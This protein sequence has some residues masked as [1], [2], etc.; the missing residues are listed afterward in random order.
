MS[1][2]QLCRFGILHEAEFI[3]RHLSGII[4]KTISKVAIVE[5]LYHALK[6]KVYSDKEA[7]RIR[8]GAVTT[9]SQRAIYRPTDACP[10]GIRTTV[11]AM[12]HFD[13]IERLWNVAGVEKSDLSIDVGNKNA[14]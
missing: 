10:C 11:L 14:I 13:R 7:R 5:V 2:L 8:L 9:T 4:N 1:I 6:L 3:L 12:L